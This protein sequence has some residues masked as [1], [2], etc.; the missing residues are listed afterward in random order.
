MFFGSFLFCQISHRKLYKRLH[1]QNRRIDQ[2]YKQKEKG[3]ETNT[4]KGARLDDEYSQKEKGR[5][6]NTRK[7]ARLDKEYRQ[8]EKGKDAHARET[9]RIDKEY[10]Q[11]E[12]G[13]DAHAR[14]TARIDKEYRQKEKGRE[15]NTRK[16]A[17]LDKEYKQKEKGRETNTRKGARIDKEYK[18]KEKGREKNTRKGARI[19]KEYRQKEKGREKNTRKGARIDK[20]YKQKEKGR[21]TN[22]RKGARLDKEYRQKE[23]GRDAH[24][25]ETARIDKEYRQKEKGREKNT[26]KGTRIDKEYKQKEKGRETNTRKRARLDDEYSQKEKGRETNTRKRA[27]LDDEYKKKETKRETPSKCKRRQQSRPSSVDG[28]INRFHKKVSEGPVYICTSCNQL[29]YRHSVEC[30][31]TSS[32]HTV[33]EILNRCPK[34]SSVENKIWMCRTCKTYV[35]KGKVPPTSVINGMKFP[36]QDVSLRTLNPLELTLLAVRLPFMKIHQAPRGK[37]KKICGNMVLVPADVDNTVTQLPRLPSNTAT[38]KATLKRRLRFKHHVYC[39]NIRPQMVRQAAHFLSKTPLYKEHVTFNNQWDVT[40]NDTG[41]DAEDIIDHERE[42]AVQDESNQPPAELETRDD[43]IVQEAVEAERNPPDA[44]KEDEDRWSEVDDEE[45]MS[46]QADTL[47]TTQD[48]IEPGDRDLLYNFAPG[49]GSVPVS[50]FLEKDSE[51]LAFPGIFCGQK[52]PNNSEREVKV[53]YAD[54]VKSELRSSD[55]RAAGNVENIFFKTKKIQMKTLIDQCQIAVR[56]VKTKNKKLTAK[57]VKGSA[58]ADLIHHDKAYKFLS[59]IRGSPPYFEK[60]SKDLFAM[61]RQLG[62]ATFFLTLSAAETK[63]LHLLKILGQVVDKRD[64]TEQELKDMSWDEKC[65]LI[66]T[67]PITCARHFDHSVST[68]L[69]DIL[70]KC[71]PIGNV[72]DYFCRVEY[73]QRG[74]PHVHMVVWIEDAPQYGRES[75]EEVCQFI[76][77]FITCHSPGEEEEEEESSLAELVPLQTHRHSHTCKKKGREKKCRFGYPKPPMRQTMILQPLTEPEFTRNQ[78]E[79]YKK[80]Y[81]DIDEFLYSI[82]EE[83]LSYEEFLLK[84]DLSEEEYILCVRASI[85]NPTV[86][87]KRS[88]KETRTNNYNETILKAWQANIDIQF[89]LDVYACAAYVASYVTKSQR[90]M[91]ELLRK[92]AEE[93]KAG[94]ATLRE[95]VRI[96]G[97]RFLNVVEIC[98]QEAV[99]ICL[100]LLMKRSS[101]QIVFVNTSPPSERVGLLKSQEILDQMDD[102]DDDIHCSNDISRYAERPKSLENVTL[103]EF[104]SFYEKKSAPRP[105]QKSSSVDPNLLQEPTSCVND[106]E[107]EDDDEMESVAVTGEQTQYRRRK[108]GRI[109]RSVHF[110]PDTDTDNYYREL[111]MLYHPWRD[112]SCLKKDDETYADRYEIL[113]EEINECRL[114]FEPYADAVAMA[115]QYLKDNEQHE[116]TWDELASENQQVDDEDFCNRKKPPDAGIEAHDIGHELGLPVSDM[117][118]DLHSYNE[119][120]DEDYRAHMRLLNPKQLEYVYDTVSQIKTASEPIYRFLSGGAGVG[121]SFVTKAIYQTAIKFLNAKAGEDFSRRTVLVMAPTGKAAYHVQG[122]TIHSALK[123]LPNKRLEHKPLACGSLNTLRN[124]ISSVKVLFIDEIS[125]VGFKMFNFINQRLMEVMQC[126]KPFGG[127]SVIAVGDLFQLKPV[128]DTYIFSLPE[129][130]YFPLSSNFWS[131]LFTMVELTD[132]MR[133][134]DNVPFAQLLNRLREGNHTPA[135]ISTLESRIIES[136]DVNYPSDATH[137]FAT[138]FKVDTFNNTELLKSGNPK[139]SFTA[140][141]RIVGPT[142]PAMKAQIIAGFKNSS[143]TKQLANVLVVSEG[144]WH[145]L[146]VNLDTSDGLINGASCIIMKM[147]VPPSVTVPRGIMWVQFQDEQIGK[148]LRSDSKCLYK[149][150]IDQRWTPIEPLVKQ[151]PAGQKGQVQL[152]RLQFPLRPAHAKTIHR[153]QGD[154]LSSAV[155]DLSGRKTDHLHYVAISRLTSLDGLNILHLQEDKI[156]VSANVKKEMARLRSSPTCIQHT[157][158][159]ALPCDFRI[160]YLNCRSMN[161]HI[162][163]VSCDRNIKA[164]DIACFSETRFTEKDLLPNTAL[165][166]YYQYRQDSKHVSDR[167]RPFHGLAVY[168]SPEFEETLNVS[169]NNVEAALFRVST[170]PDIVFVAIYKPPTVAIKDLCRALSHIHSEHLK[171]EAAVV[172]GDFNVDWASSSTAKVTLERL[173]VHELGYKQLINK[174]TTDY[175]STLDLIFTKTRS[176]KQ[177]LSG[178]REVY[179]SDHKIVWLGW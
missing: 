128:M 43:D 28:W 105:S 50:V 131:D 141:D 16:G 27:R 153:S 8:K 69:S 137:L 65:R 126:Q 74:S 39:L 34:I 46:G 48:F 107:P 20:E 42:Q 77:R 178:T 169:C 96:V 21:E 66:Q 121:K 1:Q 108:R 177:I 143:Q 78:Q 32:N 168:S 89:I 133:Q 55:R 11:K 102:E 148:K 29:W 71:C 120:N 12:K 115:E 155:I 54:I 95:Q 138:N 114:G 14:E 142:P 64:Y 139:V 82:E 122:S 75:D 26:R 116:D 179:Y 68:F 110:N 154:T 7:G 160:V 132:I 149:R 30:L 172:L 104:R 19:D 151:Y 4:R 85:S 146:T 73:Q 56:K 117:Q 18:Q 5:E 57:D 63:W 140:K 166:G 150:G 109:L 165:Q 70:L 84:F 83:Q 81:K 6:T 174:P 80:I 111:I 167:N 171:G 173:L 45:L 90:G 60:L 44:A 127:I 145:D 13:R 88:L 123:I 170:L 86:M 72:T 129:S 101:R 119:M 51:E 53:T 58:A 157:P 41:N 130:G 62:P 112:E 79:K 98:A 35:K 164:A 47:L 17:R 162:P 100:Q 124:E 97:N 152:Q 33:Q 106:D 10:R 15:T 135:D 93:V 9:A 175:G 2:E 3:R 118:E 103:A 156:S 94:N 158:L 31:P 147:D 113:K 52:R 92:A 24:A 87:L 67:D 176:R 136:S 134:K 99:Y 161:R 125:M 49:E 163:D 76:D 37:Q 144:I 40:N 91:S 23:K 59:S 36:E 61:I 25:R 38:I 159:S 22:T